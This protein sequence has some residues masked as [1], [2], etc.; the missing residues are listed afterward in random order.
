M[1]S[2]CVQLHC[3]NFLFLINN[4]KYCIHLL[5]VYIFFLSNSAHDLLSILYKK[6]FKYNYI[7]INK[8]KKK[9]SLCTLGVF[10]NPFCYVFMIFF[11][12]NFLVFFPYFLLMCF[13]RLF[14]G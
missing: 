5:N 6:N 12:C 10:S 4:C 1:V 3:H 11:G 14:R 7:L 13:V 8:K 2:M 9:N